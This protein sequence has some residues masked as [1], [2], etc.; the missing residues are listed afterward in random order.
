MGLG[1]HHPVAAAQARLRSSSVRSTQLKCLNRAAALLTAKRCDAWTLP[2][3]EVRYEN[4]LALRQ[5][6]LDLRYSANTINGTL[7]A[8]RSVLREAW[9][10][11]TIAPDIF[12]RV[13]DVPRV[14][15]PGG[16]PA[17]RML[18]HLEIRT[19]IQSAQRDRSAVGSRDVA[20]I[21]LLYGLGLRRTE[22]A[23]LDMADLRTEG[24]SVAGKGGRVDL[25]PLTRGVRNL[26]VPYLERRGRSPG[27]FLCPISRTGRIL[28]KHLS[29]SSVNQLLEDRAAAA[30]VKHFSPHDLRR[31]FVSQLL[32]RGV[33]L[34][35]V[36]KLARHNQV[37]TTERY[38]RRPLAHLHRAA[39]RL[40]L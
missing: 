1:T 14:R 24:V 11:G 18:T 13:L 20:L 8:V 23:Q 28:I 17:G 30:G 32:T 25:V 37:T 12:Q 15:P 2:W 31:S 29:G 6:L 16:A 4:V 26:L 27:P 38:D 3:T 35:E 36:Q 40:P 39:D 34:R 7:Y 21:A 19:L 5:A 9:R 33:D 10:A 22:A